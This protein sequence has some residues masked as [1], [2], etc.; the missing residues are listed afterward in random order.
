MLRPLCRRF[1]TLLLAVLLIGPYL[2]LPAAHAR[3]APMNRFVVP[4]T[5]GPVVQTGCTSIL[6]FCS[7]R[8]ALAAS[9][10]GDT[11][12]FNAGTTGTIWLDPAQGSLAVTHS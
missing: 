4:T 1:A 8:E 11:I 7:L 9:A 2:A 3:A 12:T 6:D 10:D 5:D